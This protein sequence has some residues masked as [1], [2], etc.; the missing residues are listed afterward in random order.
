[1]GTTTNCKILLWLTLIKRHICVFV[2]KENLFVLRSLQTDWNYFWNKCCNLLFLAICCSRFPLLI[3]LTSSWHEKTKTKIALWTSLRN[4]KIL[5]TK[6]LIKG[7]VVNCHFQGLHKITFEMKQIPSFFSFSSLIDCCM[8][9]F[10]LFW[11]TAFVNFEKLIKFHM[12]AFIIY[13]KIEKIWKYW[14][15]FSTKTFRF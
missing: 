10:P 1:M 15:K 7:K 5:W 12:P 4:K 14:K 11:L 6:R 8:T 3:I 9:T 2:S 13:R